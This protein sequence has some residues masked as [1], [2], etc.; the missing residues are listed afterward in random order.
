MIRASD[1]PMNKQR[2]TLA[3]FELPVIMFSFEFTAP[4]P[5][6]DR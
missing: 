2:S 4:F 5:G 3:L 6:D 1:P